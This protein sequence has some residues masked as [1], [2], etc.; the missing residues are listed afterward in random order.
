M[1]L[2]I[3]V[4]FYDSICKDIMF[5]RVVSLPYSFVRPFVHLY[6]LFIHNIL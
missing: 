5:F 6:I 2:I 1:D 4:Y 3:L